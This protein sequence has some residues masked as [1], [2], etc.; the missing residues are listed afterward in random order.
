[1][2]ASIPSSIRDAVR[3]LTD[4]TVG[5]G[6]AAE[7]VASTGPS[8]IARLCRKLATLVGDS[9]IGAVL[10]RAVK[11]VGRQLGWSASPAPSTSATH[12]PRWDAQ[13]EPIGDHLRRLDPV[14]ARTALVTLLDTF[15]TMVCTFIGETLTLRLVQE[16]T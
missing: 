15:L 11:D 1:M 4:A 14:A 6:A 2:S 9:G 16:L 13:I 10:D 5:E 8:L 3:R 12:V 7:R